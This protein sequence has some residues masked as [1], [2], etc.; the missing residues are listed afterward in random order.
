MK[1]RF[2]TITIYLLSV[3]FIISIGATTAAAKTYRLKIQSGYPRG[4]LSMELLKVF[5]DSA[6]KRSDGKV[7]IQVFAAPEIVEGGSPA[8]YEAVQRGVLDMAHQAGIF[9]SGMAPIGDVEFGLPFAFEVKKGTTFQESAAEIRDFYFNSGLVDLIREEYAKNDLH[10]LDMHSY[11]YLYVYSKKE[12]TDCSQIKNLKIASW[13]LQ[14]VF[15]K[16]IAQTAVEIAPE[17]MYMS[18]KLGMIDAALYDVSAISGLHWDEVA[19]YWL[20]DIGGD[21]IFGHIV[22]GQKQWNKLPKDIQEI[23]NA[24]AKD[25]WD[26]TVVEYEKMMNETQSKHLKRVDLGDAC[27]QSIKAAGRTTWD[28]AAKADAASAKAVELIRSRK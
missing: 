26:A 14:Q 27:R 19:P 5:S 12:I 3:L 16:K 11:G 6:K 13:G 20:A 1:K 22:I 21:M 18:L 17:E 23:V 8:V 9:A 28:D 7:I 10:W 25:Y 24:A 2:Q 15:H 4:D